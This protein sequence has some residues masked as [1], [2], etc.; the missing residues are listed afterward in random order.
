LETKDLLLRISEEQYGEKFRDHYL[1]IYKTYVVSADKI[2]ERRQTANSFFLSINTAIIG[3]V[4]YFQAGSNEKKFL[5]FHLLVSISGILVCYMWHRLVIAYKQINT[6][7]FNVIHQI[8]QKLPLSPYDAEWEVLGRG[9]DPKKYNPFTH[10]EMLV[11][12]VFLGLH[13]FVLLKVV[14]KLAS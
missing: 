10:V 11:P 9:Q 5:E 6:G 2:S 12:L 13:G 4:S 1:E 14:L 8:E 3:L 7:K